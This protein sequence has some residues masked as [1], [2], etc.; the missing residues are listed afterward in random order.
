M[1]DT[2]G[3]SDESNGHYFVSPVAIILG[4]FKRLIYS[5]N[6][7]K[8]MPDLLVALHSYPEAGRN[9]DETMVVE[10]LRNGK[11]LHFP[12]FLLNTEVDVRTQLIPDKYGFSSYFMLIN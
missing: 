7:V 9:I 12:G 1:G 6:N 10:W 5:L 8:Y 11:N 2:I 4:V 3:L